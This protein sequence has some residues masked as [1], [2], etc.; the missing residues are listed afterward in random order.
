MKL[1]YP[2][3]SRLL[4]P[5]FKTD[6]IRP[7][8]DG[9]VLHSAEGY[10]AG[11]QSVLENHPENSWHFSI[12]KDGNV[13]QHYRADQYCWHAKGGN[14]HLIGVEHEGVVGEPL[15]KLQ[16]AASVALVRWLVAEKWIPGYERSSPAQAL[17]E[18]NEVK[19]SSTACPS[20]R[21]PWAAYGPPTKGAT[22]VPSVLLQVKGK[23]QVWADSGTGVTKVA[24]QD[25]LRLG[26]K[27][28]VYPTGKPKQVTAQELAKRRR[29]AAG[30]P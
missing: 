14:A 20:D 18:H 2:A 28:G 13:H 19:G 17:Y 15:T 6:G 1:W 27:L 11:M 26:R 16:L 3:A 22:D 24:D 9:V 10:V 23:P 5:L 25:A 29:N 12:Y 30:K 8:T 4:G 7:G 21:I